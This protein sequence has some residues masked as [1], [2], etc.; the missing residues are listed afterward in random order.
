MTFLTAQAS[1]QE[2]A[3]SK[4]D[5][6]DAEHVVRFNVKNGGQ[7]HEERKHYGDPTESVEYVELQVDGCV[8]IE[9]SSLMML[10]DLNLR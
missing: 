6:V 3:Y 2:K 9:K 7:D 5:G 1:G 8:E 10:K 4:R